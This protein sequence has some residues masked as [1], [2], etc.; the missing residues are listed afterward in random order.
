MNKFTAWVANK[1]GKK[2]KPI[3]NNYT[4]ISIS[5]DEISIKHYTTEED[6]KNNKKDASK[7][8]K[9]NKKNTS[10]EDKKKNTNGEVKN[11]RKG[12]DKEDRSNNKK[13]IT[14]E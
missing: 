2:I 12:T 14:E 7:G 11:N 3:Y 8:D 13:G 5:N 4:E 9:S 6:P 1:K 10:K